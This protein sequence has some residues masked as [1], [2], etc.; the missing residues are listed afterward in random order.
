MSEYENLWES[1][2]TY[3]SGDQV[4]WID[5]TYELLRGSNKETVS[6]INECPADNTKWIRIK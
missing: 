6:S 2:I 1:S 4:K 5:Y 3:T